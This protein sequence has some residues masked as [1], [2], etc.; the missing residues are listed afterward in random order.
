MIE[1]DGSYGEG[2]GQIVRS[3]VAFAAVTQTPVRITNIRANRRKSGLAN[4]HIT[5]V[6]AVAKLCAGNHSKLTVGASTMEF[7]PKK[8]IHGV[9]E[10]D[11]GTAGSITLVLQACIL[12]ALFA[13]ADEEITIKV[14]GGTDVRWSP[15]IDY[16]YTVFLKHLELVGVKTDLK[17]IER[18]YYP[19]GGGEVQLKLWPQP[20]YGKLNITRRGDFENI[21]GIIHSRKLP[22]HITERMA[23]VLKTELH[24]YP[25]PELQ[26]KFDRNEKGIS[27]GTGV[28]IAANYSNTVLGAGALGMKG[29]PA[30]KVADNAVK[31]LRNELNGTG[32]VDV[33]A[34]DQ[35]VPFLALF[36]GE[37]SVRE[38]SLHTKTNIWL[39]EQFTNKKFRVEQKENL[40]KISI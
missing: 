1:L 19:E 26:I 39:A 13:R 33:F 10:F 28:S 27:T 5:A 40:V 35:L 29:L 31:E 12:P 3:A 20:N 37:L 21:T 25:D 34:A 15:P 38:L 14:R 23:K 36:G 11:I 30:E 16:F 7:L 17:V 8:P 32:V 2:G 24:D 4:Q 22:G 6:K 9:F 18:G